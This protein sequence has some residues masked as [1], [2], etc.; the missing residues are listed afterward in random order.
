MTLAECLKASGVDI[1]QRVGYI[2]E[3]R[4]SADKLSPIAARFGRMLTDLPDAVLEQKEFDEYDPEYDLVIQI[5]SGTEMQLC[6]LSMVDESVVYHVDPG[7]L[8]IESPCGRINIGQS[9]TFMDEVA[10]VWCALEG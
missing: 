10:R 3:S 1:S 6:L 9:Q 5:G 8:M 4:D 7:G 2:V